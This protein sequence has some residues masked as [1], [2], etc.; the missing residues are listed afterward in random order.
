MFKLDYEKAYDMI[1]RE[2][3]IDIMYKRGFSTNWMRKVKSLIYK[4]SIGV[5]VNNKNSDF[6]IAGKGVRQGT[7]IPLCFST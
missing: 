4:G 5:T 3:L 1:N 7:P 6:F 2:F